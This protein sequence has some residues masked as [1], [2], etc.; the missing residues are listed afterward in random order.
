MMRYLD[1]EATP[2]QAAEFEARLNASTELRREFALYSSMKD[3]FS[4]LALRGVEDHSVWDT[5]SSQL[6]RP[7]GWILL[8]GGALSW[9]VFGI[10]LFFVSDAA[11][12]EKLAASALGL[13]AAALL[14]ST[15]WESYRA[16]RVDPYK[17][18]HR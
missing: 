4:T 16:W 10:Y 6:A 18:V 11:L 7:T 2:D 3:D 15:A 8:V 17:D 14:G 9:F 1:G 12:F 13:G 5:V